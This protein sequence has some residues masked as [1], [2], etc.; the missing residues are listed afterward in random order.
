MPDVVS[1]LKKNKQNYYRNGWT[2]DARQ[3]DIKARRNIPVR[4]FW[5][6]MRQDQTDMTN[7]AWNRRKKMNNTSEQKI[8]A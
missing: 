6:H 8:C 1:C 7:I 4:N 5:Q 3:F 2:V